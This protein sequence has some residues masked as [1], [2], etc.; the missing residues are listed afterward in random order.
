[1]PHKKRVT[2]RF[3]LVDAVVVPTH[4]EDDIPTT[5]APGRVPGPEMI[6]QVRLL[7]QVSRDRPI[8]IV[9]SSKTAVLERTRAPGAIKPRK[10]HLGRDTSSPTQGKDAMCLPLIDFIL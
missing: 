6:M 1:M 3:E 5:S 10:A 9:K 7:A 4:G 2:R 8:A